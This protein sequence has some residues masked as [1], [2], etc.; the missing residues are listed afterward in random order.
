MAIFEEITLTW[1]G[2]EYSI[3]PNEVM[4]AIARVEEVITLSELAKFSQ[5]GNVPFSRIAMAFASV[6][7]YAGANVKDDEVYAGMFA[8]AKD[9]SAMQSIQTLLALM[10]PPSALGAKPGKLQAAPTGGKK[11]SRKPIK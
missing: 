6:L 7:R 4:G 3:K 1:A 8:G 10:V 2:A 11:S 9:N 5:N